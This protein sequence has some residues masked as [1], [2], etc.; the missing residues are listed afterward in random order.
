MED[1][2]VKLL[3]YHESVSARLK[4]MLSGKTGHTFNFVTDQA[5][6]GLLLSPERNHASCYTGIRYFSSGKRLPVE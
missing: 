2:N 1:R 4:G 6:R 5:S 3:L